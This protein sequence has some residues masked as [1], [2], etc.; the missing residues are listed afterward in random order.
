[1]AA[2]A[3]AGFGLLLVAAFGVRTVLHRRRTG[4]SGWLAPPTPAARVGDGLFTLGVAGTF[5]VPALDLAGILQPVEALDTPAVSMPGAVLLAAGALVA[6]SAQAQMGVA[7]RAGIDASP[8]DPLVR[9][10]WFGVVRHPF[11]VGMMLASA[12]VALS[13]PNALGALALASLVAGSEIDVRL[14][15]EPRLL[16]SYGPAY[17][18]YAARVGRFVPLVGRLP[19]S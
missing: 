18:E 3:L 9:R 13:A 15:E 5:G 6:L 10:G 11:Y 19:A 1:M 16:A 4:S 2:F 8:E 17:R 7:W 14:V 12:G